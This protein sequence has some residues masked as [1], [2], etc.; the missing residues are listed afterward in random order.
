MTSSEQSIFRDPLCIPKSNSLGVDENHLFHCFW[1]SQKLTARAIRKYEVCHFYNKL[2]E[3]WQILRSSRT[4]AASVMC[5]SWPKTRKMFY[6]DKITPE[7]PQ[8]ATVSLESSDKS[9]ATGGALTVKTDTAVL[10]ST[11]DNEM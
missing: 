6:S 5:I 3:L 1:F 7:I 8:R 4:Q 10:I 9:K 11:K 2:K